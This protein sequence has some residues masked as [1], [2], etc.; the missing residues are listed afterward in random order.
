MNAPLTSSAGRLFD[1][2]ASLI[3]LRQQ[4]SFEGQAA[5][6]MEFAVQA[7]IEE[8]YPFSLGEGPPS[9]IDWDPAIRGIL[10]DRRSGKSAGAIS[11]K[12]H[13][14][15]AEAIVAIA[16]KIGE[17][18]VVLSGGCFQN[19]YLTERTIDRLRQE[20]FRPYWHQRVPP[21]DGGIALGQVAAVVWSRKTS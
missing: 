16:R 20:N 21:N 3:G 4:A 9:V 8:A 19:R 12:F 13:N 6:E 1:A 17:P 5:M 11:A 2:V 18:K 10:D 15:L 14:M 7:G